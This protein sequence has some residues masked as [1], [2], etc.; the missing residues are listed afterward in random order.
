MP[1]NGLR[2]TC[3]RL[4]PVGLRSPSSSSA[5]SGC[6]AASGSRPPA[7]LRGRLAADAAIRKQMPLAAGSVSSKCLLDRMPPE[8]MGNSFRHLS[9]FGLSKQI[10][11]VRNGTGRKLGRSTLGHPNGS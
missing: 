5:V 6:F 3:G 4:R 10:R 8:G 11:F 9:L 7:L 1:T 2:L